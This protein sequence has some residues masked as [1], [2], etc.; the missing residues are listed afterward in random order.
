MG[1]GWGVDESF[2]H[3]PQR[4]FPNVGSSSHWT[5]YLL[6]YSTLTSGSTTAVSIALCCSN[7]QPRLSHTS[8][9]QLSNEKIDNYVILIKL[10]YSYTDKEI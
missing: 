9:I 4:A 2:M 6:L 3:D 10:P 7:L 5:L 1:S 8:S